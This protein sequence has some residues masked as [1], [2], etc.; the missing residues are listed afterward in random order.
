MYSWVKGGCGGVA[1]FLQQERR[2]GL[3]SSVCGTVE[4]EVSEKFYDRNIYIERGEGERG[5]E[6]FVF[7]FGYNV[8][9]EQGKGQGPTTEEETECHCVFN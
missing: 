4:R 3:D 1:E 5:R 6:S 2:S 8:I 7:V 9:A